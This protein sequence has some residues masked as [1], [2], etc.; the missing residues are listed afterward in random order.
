MLTPIL[1]P[2]TTHVYIRVNCLKPPL[3]PGYKGPYR[4]V[5]RFRKYFEVDI[6]THVERISIDRLKTA[7]SSIELLNSCPAAPATPT[8]HTTPDENAQAF[9][10]LPEDISQLEVSLS[11]S[12]QSRQNTIAIMEPSL[13]TLTEQ[14][15]PAYT[16]RGRMVNLPARLH[17]YH[18]HY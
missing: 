3:H 14:N 5:K 4:V 17:D 16:L 7:Y 8:S 15:S 13:D 9:T 2:A 12:P 11:G 1:S 10:T 18:L 6:R